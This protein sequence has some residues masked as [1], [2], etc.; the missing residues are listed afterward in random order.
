MRILNTSP[1]RL[2]HAASI[3]SLST[4][5]CLIGLKLITFFM[6]GSVAI[7]SS[8][9]DSIQDGMSS[10]VNYI[11][12][13]HAGIPADKE[14][15]F[16][17]GKAQA[18]GSLIQ[19]F[20]I[21]IAALFLLVEGYAR[22]LHPVPIEAA[23]SGLAVTLFALFVTG[24]LVLFQTYVIAQTNSLS[25]K[26]DRAHYTGDI[27]MNIGVI[28]SLVL[29]H[30]LGW[31]QVD[32]L[33]GIGVGI[34]LFYLVYQIG[35]EAFAMLMDTEMPDD[36]RQ[37]VQNTALSFPEVIEVDQLKTRLSGSQP[38]IQFCIRLNENL[39]LKQAHDVTDKIEEAIRRV[40]TQA[41]IIIHPEPVTK[42][43]RKTV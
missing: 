33:F 30:Y 31:M 43:K 10:L 34:Y 27:G 15:R 22:F 37:C 13:R 40:Y 21:T 29:S 6:T 20:I 11:A 18:I 12:V 9:F 25:I 19:A 2:M 17:H 28:L 32:A 16:G 42:K 14:H 39:T 24:G 7:L 1:Q 23:A 26:A 38:F 35:K 8:L 4:A 5:V 3:A 41:D 36:F